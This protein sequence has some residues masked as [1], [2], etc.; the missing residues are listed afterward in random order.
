MSE[1]VLQ[2]GSSAHPQ[3][4]LVLSPDWNYVTIRRSDDHDDC[5][6]FASAL[7]GELISTLREIERSLEK[8]KVVN[9]LEDVHLGF[10][11]EKTRKRSNR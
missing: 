5:F 4:E 11:K 9:A 6:Q 8:K 3:M 1:K 2:V 7:V 10:E